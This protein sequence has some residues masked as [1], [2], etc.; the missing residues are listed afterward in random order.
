MPPSALGRALSHANEPIAGYQGQSKRFAPY[1][2][3]R[4]RKKE[5]AA[6]G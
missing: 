5:E 4:I 1:L 6:W 2:F 3:P